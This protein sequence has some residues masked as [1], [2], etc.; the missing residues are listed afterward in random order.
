[1]RGLKKRKEAADEEANLALNEYELSLKKLDDK[2]ELGGCDMDV[3][4]GRRVFGVPK[5][6][7]SE[8]SKKVKSDSYYASDDSENDDAERE[9][10]VIEHEKDNHSLRLSDIDPNFLRQVFEI[11]HDSAFKVID[12]LLIFIRSLKIFYQ[13]ILEKL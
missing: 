9:D 3:S 5:K 11:N 10:E 6:A 13:V 8:T 4:S 2:S 1:M 12:L 7:V